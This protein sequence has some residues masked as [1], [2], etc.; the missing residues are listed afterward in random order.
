MLLDGVDGVHEAELQKATIV[1][2]HREAVNADGRSEFLKATAG[3][4]TNEKETG[5]AGMR[6]IEKTSVKTEVFYLLN[7]LYV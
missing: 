1:A 4:A 7:E 2:R 5:I 3:C 6:R